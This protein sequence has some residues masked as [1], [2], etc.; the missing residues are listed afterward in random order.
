MKEMLL[1]DLVAQYR[2]IYPEPYD[3]ETTAEYLYSEEPEHMAELTKSLLEKGWREPVILQPLDE[4]AEQDD[5]PYVGDGTHRVVIA[6]THGVFTVPVI[7]RSEQ[8][9]EYEKQPLEIIIENVGG[10][11]T[12]QEDE[13]LF[14]SFRSFRLNEDIWLTSDVIFGSGERREIVLSFDDETLCPQIKSKTRDILKR[15][16]P[17]RNFTVTVAPAKPLEDEA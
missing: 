17:G 15:L 13:R 6:L 12:E 11:L 4:D 5:F 2:P 7:Y 10:S 16:F 14:D 3:W 1:A 8:P 9:T